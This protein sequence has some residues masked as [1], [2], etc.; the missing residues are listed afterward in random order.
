M[1]PILNLTWGAAEGRGDPVPP[2]CPQGPLR[3]ANRKTS[4]ALKIKFKQKSTLSSLSQSKKKKKGKIDKKKK[5]LSGR[6]RQE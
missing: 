1:G 2:A 4:H 3:Q 5:G 6:K